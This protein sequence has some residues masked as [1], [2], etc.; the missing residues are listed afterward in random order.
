MKRKA[1]ALAALDLE[2]DHR[3]AARHLPLGELRLRMI[4]AAGIEHADD[5]LPLGKEIGDRRRRRAMALDPQRQGLESL[6]QHPGIERAERRAG[7]LEV[8]CAACP[9]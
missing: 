6:E 2:S 1:L 5:L 7:L 8:R 9:R 3:T 4:G